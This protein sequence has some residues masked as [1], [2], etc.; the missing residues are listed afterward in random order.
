M[1]PV[2]TITSV[3]EPQR[4]S[5]KIQRIPRNPRAAR[6]GLSGILTPEMSASHSVSGSS[7]NRSVTQIHRATTHGRRRLTASPSAP[8]APDSRTASAAQRA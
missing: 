6:N 7:R 4:P 1:A 5:P 2:P 3:S 8:I